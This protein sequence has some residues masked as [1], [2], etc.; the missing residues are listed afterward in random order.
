MKIK[1][2]IFLLALPALLSCNLKTEGQSTDTVDRI[3]QS[4]QAFVKKG[5]E[6]PGEFLRSIPFSVTTT[7]IADYPDGIIPFSNL[8]KPDQ[9]IPNLKNGTDIIINEKVITVIIDY[10]VRDQYRFDLRSDTGFTR[11]LLL[12]KISEAY[13]KMYEEEEASATVKTIPVEKRTTIYNRNETN[14]KYGIWGHDIADL[15]LSGVDVYKGK[16]GKI[17]V[18][19]GIES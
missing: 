13:Y 10:P 9:D 19:L 1:K 8:E 4:E 15:V 14:G 12:K 18:T 17:V 2:L 6:S 11:A 3:K 16:D 7:N 5:P